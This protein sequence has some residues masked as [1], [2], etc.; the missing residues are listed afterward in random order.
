MGVGTRPVAAIACL[1]ATDRNEPQAA[2]RR[3]AHILFLSANNGNQRHNIHK[4]LQLNEIAASSMISLG[5]YVHSPDN[6]I[7]A[8]LSNKELS[9]ALYDF[10][11]D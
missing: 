7:V 10:D 11:P 1:G 6:L 8:G 3:I 2:G 9:I 4:N 5:R